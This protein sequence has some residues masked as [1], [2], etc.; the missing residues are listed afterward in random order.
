MKI[1]MLSAVI[2]LL[3][4]ST[5]ACENDDT[6][7]ILPIEQPD[8]TFLW[9]GISLVRDNDIID[10]KTLHRLPGE[11]PIL[12]NVITT[13]D[14]TLTILMRSG[15]AFPVLQYGIDEFVQVYL[16]GEWYT[17]LYQFAQSEEPLRLSEWD[18]DASTRRG[19]LIEHTV[20]LSAVSELFPGRYRFVWKFY[21]EYR[22][23][24]RYTFVYFWVINL[25]DAR[26]PESETTGK[27]RREDIV[28]HVASPY[29]ARRSITDIDIWFAVFVENLSGKSYIA[30]PEDVVLEM[31]Q[32]NRWREIDFD[33]ANVGM[34]SAWTSD[35]KVIFLNE[36]LAAGRYRIR[37]QAHTFDV[38]DYNVTLEHEFDVIAYE[39][40][41]E[42][43]WDIS[44]LRRSR[45][46]A[47]NQSAGIRISSANPV[48][49]RDNPTLEVLFS[50]D[51][52]YSYGVPYEVEVLLDGMWYRVPFV[53]T[54]MFALIGLSIRPNE[55]H[56]ATYNPVDSVG[57]LPAGQYR[58]VKE[59]TEFY[60]R[61]DYSRE[62]IASEIAMVE[63][64]V[65][66]TLEW[67]RSF[68]W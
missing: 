61:E 9:N 34:L 58:I 21:D 64:T 54:T 45:H 48:L 27:A 49:D 25:G 35:T 38:Q 50:A 31:R 18:G 11:P 63:F 2:I 12:E 56:V 17:L 32:G 66:E 37:L 47:A 65:Q 30:E 41:S 22:G 28:L 39:Y 1:L 10:Q 24:G 16:D 7:V 5:V 36:P 19:Y 29:E 42:P 44:R 53:P 68:D 3:L 26:P 51:R 55:E 20:D 57:I 40:A 8:G 23:E 43:K 13:K 60:Q 4:C 62:F 52:Y 14:R 33:H 15:G 59:F 67:S 6:P 46:D